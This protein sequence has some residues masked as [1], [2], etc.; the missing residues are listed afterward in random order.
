MLNKIIKDMKIFKRNKVSVEKKI[1]SICMFIQG[2][3]VRRISR[4]TG[5][6]KTAVHY[7][8][9]KFRENINYNSEKKKRHRI[10]I[11]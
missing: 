3:G 4:I 2:L 10:A 8:T 5:L 11:D 9:I 1:L 7:L 6:S